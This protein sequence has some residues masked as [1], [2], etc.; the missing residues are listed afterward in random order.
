M[1][2]NDDWHDDAD[3]RYGRHEYYPH[4]DDD[5]HPS[6]PV[7][8]HDRHKTHDRRDDRRDDTHDDRNPIGPGRR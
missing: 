3:D 6:T 2:I 5:I 8:P 4:S 1:D 7:M